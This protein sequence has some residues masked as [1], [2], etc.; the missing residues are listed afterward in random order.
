MMLLLLATTG[1]LSFTSTGSIT[2]ASIH[3]SINSK[4]EVYRDDWGVPHIYAKKISDAY[5]ALGYVMAEDRLFEMDLFRRAVSG[6]LG[7]IFGNLM[8]QDDVLM[9]TL[10][11]YQIA[12]DTWNGLYPDVIIP[13]DLKENLE[14]FS[15]GVNH[16][17]TTMP[18]ER[19]PLE[20]N[21]LQL[22]TGLPTEYFIPYPWTPPDSVAI[23][24]MMG[25]ML[26][27]TSSGEI[28]RGA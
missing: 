11:I 22:T 4:V 6:R 14:Q 1:F 26:T 28:V 19:I 25:L 23:A 10:G 12:V 5:F 24:G 20:Y 17:I 13:E 16:Y 2:N 27:D 21:A 9:R 8:F 3:A 7:E 15:N 18:I